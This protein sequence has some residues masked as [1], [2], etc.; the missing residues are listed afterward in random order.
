FFIE[1]GYFDVTN[2]AL[3]RPQEIRFSW[4][5]VPA[6]FLTSS[7]ET[8]AFSCNPAE[9]TVRHAFRRV[10]DTDYEPVHWDGLRF[11]AAG[12]F[13]NQRKGYDRQRGTVDDRWYRFASRYNIWER[14]HWYED[15]E[16]MTGAIACATPETTE[17]GQ[18]PNRDEDGDGTE[19]ECAAV[20]RGSRCDTF[21]QRCT[22]PY[23]DRTVKPV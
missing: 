14:S 12:A 1:E 13:T 11:T 9:I 17:P 16:S 7:P 2:K 5:S 4:G 20:G 19:D 3:A 8:A 10:V 22:L 18:D 15:P 6:C 23:R 21:R